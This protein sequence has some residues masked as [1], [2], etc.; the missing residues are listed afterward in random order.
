MKVPALWASVAVAVRALWLASTGPVIA[1]D[2]HIYARTA[3]RL[4]RGMGFVDTW[5]NLPPYRPTAF[6]PVGYPA[7]LG[8]GYRV[9]GPSP[10]VAAGL[11]LLASAAVTASAVLLAQRASSR[12]GAHLAGALT[13]L[14]PGGVMYV[15]TYMTE[16][17]SAALLVLAV[18]FLARHGHQGKRGSALAAGLCLGVGGLLRPQVLLLAPVLALASAEGAR[19]RVGALG[20]TGLACALCVLPWTARNC[21]R[22]DGCALVSVNGGSNLW[23]GADPAARGGYRDLR[24]R[25][26][27]DRVHGEVAKDRC[28]G[29]LALGRIAGDPIGW[30][31]LAFDKVHELLDFEA[32]PAAY[33]RDAAAPSAARDRLFLRREAALT[34]GHRALCAL[35]LLAVVLRA[36]GAAWTLEARLAAWAVGGSVAVH[37]VFFGGDRYHLVFSPL[38]AVL[39]STTLPRR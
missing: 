8:L 35:A 29:R 31:S 14:L 24:P 22:L 36:R 4:A 27:C 32:A 12:H 6:Y 34:G 26:G 15:S 30:A 21:V 1:W 23:I 18:L 13:A 37:A 25:E 20:W 28:Y 2:G 5:N 33:L 10:W 9:V 16:P 38:L 7:L 19:R 39:A 17:V 11:N 3:L